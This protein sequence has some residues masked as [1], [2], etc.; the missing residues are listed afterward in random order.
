MPLREEA[1]PIHDIQVTFAPGYRV[2]GVRL[3]PEGKDLAVETTAAGA[4]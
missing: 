4:A 2:Q 1:V 3:E